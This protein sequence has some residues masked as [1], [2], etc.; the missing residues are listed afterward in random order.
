MEI[1]KQMERIKVLTSMVN[2]ELEH[3]TGLKEKE[4][5]Y[6]AQDA[7]DRDWRNYPATACASRS[8]RLMLVL[9]QEMIKLEK[10]M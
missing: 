3:Y 8:K 1:V 5:V 2:D 10:M 9:R 6:M 7:E 4:R